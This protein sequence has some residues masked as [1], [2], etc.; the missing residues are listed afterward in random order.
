MA[1]TLLNQTSLKYAPNYLGFDPRTETPKFV[2]IDNTSLDND[3]NID[4][5]IQMLKDGIITR[6]DLPDGTIEKILS[7][8][9][10]GPEQEE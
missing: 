8:I 1:K 5:L 4:L 6:E 3:E 7:K 10:F 2:V 9:G